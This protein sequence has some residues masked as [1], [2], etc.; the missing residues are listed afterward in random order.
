VNEQ[1][2]VLKQRRDLSQII[3]AS[4]NIY[5]QNFRPLF[6][7]AC[8]VIP[9]GIA[10]AV[11]QEA[12]GTGVGPGIATAVLGLAQGV[13]YV[14][15]WCALVA[16][17]GDFEQGKAID[18]SR[19]YDAAF[20]RFL[21]LIVAGLRAAFHVLLF[22]IT[23]IGIPW[24]I[25]RAVR[26]TFIGQAV[27]LDGTSAKAALAYSAD[28]VIGSW[29]RTLGILIVVSI[30]IGVPSSIVSAI[31]ILAPPIVSGT[32]SAVVVALGLP[33]YAIATTLLYLDLK[34]RKETVAADTELP[35]S[36]ADESNP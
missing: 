2:I 30:L 7:I 13:V 35:T 14:I 18:F 19:A 29:W 23:I 9:L 16:G 6:L 28:A 27:I 20:D 25:Q 33:L 21:T 36:N 8:V 31:F 32:V 15:A 1:R 34:T 5:L 24:G 3:E 22:Y 10:S 17:L 4:V 11:L 12:I 26:W